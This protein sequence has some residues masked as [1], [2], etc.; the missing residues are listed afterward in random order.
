MKLHTGGSW[1]Q[2]DNGGIKLASAS[3]YRGSDNLG[4]YLAVVSQW[5]L[6]TGPTIET[7]IRQYE[8]PLNTVRCDHKAVAFSIVYF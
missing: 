5:N 3:E 7:E 8:M 4:V 6:K 2:T 1:L